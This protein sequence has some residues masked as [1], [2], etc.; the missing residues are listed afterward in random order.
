MVVQLRK[1]AFEAKAEAAVARNP[2]TTFLFINLILNKKKDPIC[3]H[4]LKMEL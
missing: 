1:N 3:F 4:P 2:F